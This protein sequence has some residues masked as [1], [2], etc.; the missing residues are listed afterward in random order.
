[1]HSRLCHQSEPRRRPLINHPQHGLP[2]G[3]R[4]Q[5]LEPVLGDEDVVLDAHAADVPVAVELGLV[6]VLGVL[7]V[8]EEVA[9]DVLAAEV[10]V[11][12]SSVSS[13]CLDRE[14]G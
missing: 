4:R 7:G 2:L 9:L 12:W 8:L 6:D 14:K 1:M 10:A 5:V 11:G 13:E 3:R